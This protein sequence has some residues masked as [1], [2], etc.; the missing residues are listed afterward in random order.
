MDLPC[1]VTPFRIPESIKMHSDWIE[2]ATLERES[3][4]IYR[5]GDMGEDPVWFPQK[6]MLILGES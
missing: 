1:S 6:P 4:I 3:P 5:A 2:Q